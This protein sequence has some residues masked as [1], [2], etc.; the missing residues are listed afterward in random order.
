MKNILVT[1]GAGYI[2]SHLVYELIRQKYTPIVI[3]NLSNSNI[4]TLKN[5]NKIFNVKIKFYKFDLFDENKLENVFKKHNI[6]FVLHFAA[7][8]NLTQSKREVFSYY[9]N[10]F[11]AT[12]NLLK[13]MKKFKVLNIIFASTAAQSSLKNDKSQ[14]ASPYGNSKMFCELF[15]QD[16][17]KTNA[18]WNMVILNIYNV[19]GLNIN[20]F[21][22]KK[23]S[24]QNSLIE[25]I[26]LVLK[27]KKKYLNIYGNDFKTKD[28]TCVRD[29]VDIHDVVATN[30]NIIKK[31]FKKKFKS[32][33]VC[34][35]K[36]YSIKEI[37]FNFEN[38]YK[39]KIK[40][41]IKKRKSE[42]IPISIGPK[43]TRHR[44]ISLKTT[45]QNYKKI[46]KNLHI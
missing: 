21:Y 39:K 7:L 35:G 25:N 9:S 5:I 18:K 44:N 6:N 27:N 40:I 2:G 29:F 28:G 1:G 10:N 8:K 38:V 15:M 24:K 31:K 46:F 45:I 32:E 33:N 36:G 34:N 14:Y 12:I 41:K 13:V 4:E 22:R 17:S 42:D 26:L 19:I 30:I 37:V 11:L 20:N 23:N 43:K 3:D 16:L